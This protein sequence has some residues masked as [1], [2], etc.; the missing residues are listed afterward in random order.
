MGCVRVA[1]MVDVDYGDGDGDTPSSRCDCVLSMAEL[2]PL[3]CAAAAS[4]LLHAGAFFVYYFWRR[5]SGLFLFVSALVDWVDD[6][7]QP[8]SRFHVCL[9]HDTIL[10]FFVRPRDSINASREMK[11]Y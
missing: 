6:D 3:R 10:S 4:F 9:L 11:M 8:F 5:R 1:M 7:P 2:G